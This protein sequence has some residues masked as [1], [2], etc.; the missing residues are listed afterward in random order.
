MKTMRV[1]FVFALLLIFSSAFAV[2]RLVGSFAQAGYTDWDPG[3]GSLQMTYVSGTIYTITLSLPAGTYSYKI[4]DGTSW[5]D[6]N[7]PGNNQG[8]TLGSTTATTFVCNN[9]ARLVMHTAP[10]IAGNFISELGGA[11]WTPSDITGLMTI[12]PSPLQF[13]Q[14]EGLIPSGTWDFKVTLNGNWDQSTTSNNI[15]FIS[16]GISSTII[17]YNF[18]TNTVS[19]SAGAPPTAP[20][21]FTVDDRSHTHT[22]FY[23][24]GSW[25]SGGYYDVTW[26]GG[27]EH[28]ALTDDG[29][30]GDVTAG[31]HIFTAVQNLVTDGGSNTWYWG[32]ND[33]NHNWF[34]SSY[35][36]FTLPTTNAQSR[37]IIIPEVDLPVELSSFT[38]LNFNETTVSVQW[39]SQS[40][41][42]LLGYNVFRNTS[43]D[44]NTSSLLNSR[45]IAA[46]NSSQE[47]TYSLLDN[48]LTTD[49]TYFYWLESVDMDGSSTLHG[50]V[51]LFFSIS[52]PET[53]NPN[54][55]TATTLFAAYPNPF[56]PQTT[57][58]FRLKTGAQSNLNVYNVKGELIKRLFNGP[59][60]AGTYR[61]SWDGTDLNGKQVGSGVYYY[62]L[63]A[64]K[65]HQTNKMVLMK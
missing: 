62:R 27:V 52:D 33:E 31:D 18:D 24:K 26:A 1:L 3:N 36:T 4:V 39:V 38:A 41:T 59:L 65:Y 12:Q 10:I 23:L 43:A 11:D 25:N 5:S 32:L 16:D 58:S 8:F 15:T 60:A 40:E 57:L 51:T 14:W 22:A 6:P 9:T 64:G 20:I 2:P 45:I 19:T 54:I 7:Y 29:L 48:E 17:S 42:E 35:Q 49:N 47:H 30:N 46:T 63:D 44:I 13:Y 28:I 50:P 53:P 55:P 61:W 21:T 56:N 34:D 37:E